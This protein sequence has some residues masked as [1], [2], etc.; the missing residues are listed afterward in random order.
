MA[1][2][3]ANRL[4]EEGTRNMAGM[5]GRIFA[6]PASDVNQWTEPAA[7]ATTLATDITC[8]TGK[9]F[10]EIYMTDET[11]QVEDQ[12]VGEKD[13][14]SWET[15]IEWWSP[16]IDEALLQLKANFA[17]GGFVFIVEDAQKVKRI[18]GSPELPAY[19]VPDKVSTG[20]A[21]KDRRGAGFK[22]MAPSPAP[23]LIYTGDV[24]LTP[25]A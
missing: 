25:A 6:A 11:G 24:P 12:E 13:G 8:K 19:R 14:G 22:F 3:L 2:T 5:R 21:R 20:K 9:K 18:V 16:S 4:F 15:T 7:G 10:V 17:N 23:A 1:I